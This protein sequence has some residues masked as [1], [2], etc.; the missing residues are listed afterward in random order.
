MRRRRAGPTGATAPVLLAVAL[1]ASGIGLA[2]GSTLK[3]SKGTV[4]RGQGTGVGFSGVG[5][6]WSFEKVTSGVVA[7]VARL[8]NLSAAAPSVLPANGSVDLLLA[9]GTAGA[10]AE[11]WTFFAS[12][13]APRSTELELRFGLSGSSGSA[14]ATLYVEV[15]P[16]GVASTVTVRLYLPTTGGSPSVLTTT[17]VAADSFGCAAVGS[18]P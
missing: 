10:S 7:G 18:C 5:S 14:T 9:N 15:G 6:W 12:T 2:A 4:E 13:A 1:V 3:I 11:I 17:A 8:G 16:A